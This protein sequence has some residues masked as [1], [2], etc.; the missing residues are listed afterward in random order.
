MVVLL[1]YV[2]SISG[3]RIYL[4]LSRYTFNNNNNNKNQTTWLTVAKGL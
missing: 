3:N 1:T 2:F 4:K